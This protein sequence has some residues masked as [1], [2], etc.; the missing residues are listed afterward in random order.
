V[1]ALV[2]CQFAIKKSRFGIN[3][4]GLIIIEQLKSRRL[5]MG[6]VEFKYSDEMTEDNMLLNHVSAQC[7]DDDIEIGGNNLIDVL[8]SAVKRR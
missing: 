4:K 5:E 3:I 8:H 1:A 6:S 2:S 7:P